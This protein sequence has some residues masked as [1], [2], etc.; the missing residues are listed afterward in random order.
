MSYTK[1]KK[2]KIFF[3]RIPLTRLPNKMF[4][5][6]LFQKLGLHLN[7][8]GD[9]F[10]VHL[11]NENAISK[12]T[13]FDLLD[14]ICRHENLKCIGEN[15]KIIPYE[16]GSELLLNAL[17]YDLVYQTWEIT[18]LQE[19]LDLRNQILSNI[20]SENCICLTN[21]GQNPW[22]NN[23]SGGWTAITDKLYDMA[24]VFADSQS[25]LFTYFKGED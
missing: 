21:W 11:D 8:S 14:E 19:A 7:Y 10:M 9:S 5:T 3:I 4:K 22:K 6:D 18:S 13:I 20:H 23:Q 16:D 15:W 25:I 2:F 12:N 17:N 24:I 1:E